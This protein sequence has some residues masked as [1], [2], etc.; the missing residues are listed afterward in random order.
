MLAFTFKKPLKSLVYIIVF[1]KKETLAPLSILREIYFKPPNRPLVQAIAHAA[2]IFFASKLL[3]GF[4]GSDTHHPAPWHCCG[5]LEEH[6][7]VQTLT[8]SIFIALHSNK[9]FSSVCSASL[10]T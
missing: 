5:S 10:R 1:F 3:L 9:C 7:K 8:N 2:H 6:R 4:Q